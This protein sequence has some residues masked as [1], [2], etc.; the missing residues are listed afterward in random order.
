MASLCVEAFLSKPENIRLGKRCTFNFACVEPQS[1]PGKSSLLFTCSRSG[2]RVFS[3]I[4]HRCRLNSGRDADSD[5]EVMGWILMVGFG[6]LECY[7]F[8]L[9]LQ[10]LG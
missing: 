5:L 1:C 9:I 3:P 8:P 2:Y 4:G 10:R 7:L 6:G